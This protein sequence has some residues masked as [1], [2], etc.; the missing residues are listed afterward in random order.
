M[1]DFNKDI[2]TVVVVTYN[3]AKF[4]LETLDSIACQDYKNIELIVSDDCSQDNTIEI[5]QQWIADNCLRFNGAKVVQTP[6]NS[7]ICGNYNFALNFVSGKVIKYIAGD[8]ILYSNCISRLVTA[9]NEGHHKIFFSS[10]TPFYVENEKKHFCNTRGTGSVVFANYDPRKQLEKL[11]EIIYHAT[12]G[13]TLFVETETL[14]RLG[15]MDE[16]YPMLEDFPIA[17]KFLYND[18]TIGYINE[19]LVYYREYSESVSKSNKKFESMFLE[20][21]YDYRIKVARRSTKYIQLWHWAILR[22]IVKL[23]AG[24]HHTLRQF[25]KVLLLTDIYALQNKVQSIACQ[26]SKP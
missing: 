10:L 7:G 3:S 18:Y 11:F 20:S 21:L 8:D 25:A 2:V 4:I 13:P 5:C 26:T 23:T 14:R 24:E 16:K 1:Y 9:Y 17:L 15:G 6:K 22:L 12:E 19:P